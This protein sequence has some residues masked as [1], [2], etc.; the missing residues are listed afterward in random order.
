MKQKRV[1]EN[2]MYFLTK[3]MA[4]ITIT[5]FYKRKKAFVHFLSKWFEY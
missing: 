2:I 1:Y 4:I 3:I 5:F